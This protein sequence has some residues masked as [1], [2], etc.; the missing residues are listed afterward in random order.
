MGQ[1]SSKFWEKNLNSA[2]LNINGIES[3]AETDVHWKPP[4]S[5]ASL[6]DAL[7]D[8]D[9]AMTPQGLRC[10]DVPVG[11]PVNRSRVSY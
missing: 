6:R 11:A 3:R 9:G 2:T 7:L 5:I 10:A 1:N 4:E 8:F